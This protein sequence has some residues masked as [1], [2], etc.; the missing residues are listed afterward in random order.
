[1]I[2]FFQRYSFGCDR[3]L[4]IGLL[5]WLTN[6]ILHVCVCANAFICVRSIA[7]VHSSLINK[8]AAILHH[9]RVNTSRKNLSQL[10]LSQNPSVFSLRRLSNRIVND[11]FI[12]IWL[13]SSDGFQRNI[14]I[15]VTIVRWSILYGFN[16]DS[17]RDEPSS[18]FHMLMKNRVTKSIFNT[19]C[20]NY[21]D[22]LLQCGFL[23]LHID[24][25]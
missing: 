23:S 13:Y 25:Y 14:T 9:H 6:A 10:S 20:S 22:I 12:S 7:K 4:P 24:S 2:I 15:F 11:W 18:R 21:S 1:M 16:L 5:M 3:C 17:S 19:Q 8:F